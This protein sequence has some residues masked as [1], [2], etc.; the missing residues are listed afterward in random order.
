[1][2]PWKTETS[3]VFLV[4]S[5]TNVRWLCFGVCVASFLY[6]QFLCNIFKACLSADL[7][8]GNGN[9]ENKPIQSYFEYNELRRTVG[10]FQN[11][12]LVYEAIMACCR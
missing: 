5:I 9:K 2:R 7:A 11:G 3:F 4:L 1:M 8:N 6:R 10:Y 12:A